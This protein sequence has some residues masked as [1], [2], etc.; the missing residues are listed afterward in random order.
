MNPRK[1]TRRRGGQGWEE[2]QNAK[3][4]ALIYSANLGVFPSSLSL[5]TGRVPWLIGWFGAIARVMQGVCLA[6]SRPLVQ[7]A[8]PLQS[9]EVWTVVCC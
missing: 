9:K 7:I 8:S 1:R 2:R 5:T 3:F 4:P 6:S